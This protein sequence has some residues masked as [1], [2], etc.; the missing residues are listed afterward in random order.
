MAE[1]RTERR[2]FP[3]ERL[4]RRRGYR[5][6]KRKKKSRELD[7]TELPESKTNTAAAMN[8]I[9]CCREKLRVGTREQVGKETSGV[10]RNQDRWKSEG[11]I[12]G[13]V[14]EQSLQKGGRIIKPRKV[15]K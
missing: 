2:S 4:K 1:K 10:G 6:R 11:K 3:R 5:G 7:E 15:V 13:E 8:R 12:F 14:G 9:T